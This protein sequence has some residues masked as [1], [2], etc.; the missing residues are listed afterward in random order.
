[1]SSAPA[2]NRTVLSFCLPFSSIETVCEPSAHLRHVMRSKKSTRLLRYSTPAASAGG[3]GSAGGGGSGGSDLGGDGDGDVTSGIDSASVKDD[4]DET[5]GKVG[6]RQRQLQER[7][8]AQGSEKFP[9]GKHLDDTQGGNEDVDED[10]NENDDEDEAGD[11]QE[12]Q[13]GDSRAY[14][15]QVAEA[16]MAVP[17]VLPHAAGTIVPGS[18][19]VA[20]SLVSPARVLRSGSEGLGI[21]V[22]DTILSVP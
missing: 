22:H 14:K 19:Q 9:K 21:Y 15:G 8:Q 7:S 16:L 1:M 13:E 2:L 6:Q 18:K 12:G 17:V 3:A 4:K 20:A 10:K 5:K 11:G